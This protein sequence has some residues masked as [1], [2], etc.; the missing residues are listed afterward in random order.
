MNNSKKKIFPQAILALKEALSVIFWKKDD[1]MDFLK[2]TIERKTIISTINWGG[3][4]RESV[5]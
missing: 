1:L 4:K 2:L 5:K 3:L